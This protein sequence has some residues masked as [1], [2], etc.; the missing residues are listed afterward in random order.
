MLKN[1]RKYVTSHIESDI[2][3]ILDNHTNQFR[4]KQKTQ[5]ICAKKLQKTKKGNYDEYVFPSNSDTATKNWLLPY[6]PP[7]FCPQNVDFVISMQFL[8]ILPKMSY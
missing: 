4:C 5:K 2:L 3:I 1:T 8:A 7:L 6:V